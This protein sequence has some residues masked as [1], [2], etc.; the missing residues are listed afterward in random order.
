MKHFYLAM[1][2]LLLAACQQEVL[3]HDSS[4]VSQFT[5]MGVDGWQVSR[6][7]QPRIAGRASDPN[8][9]V[10]READFSGMRFDTS[11]QIDDPRYRQAATQPSRA[12][13]TAPAGPQPMLV[14]FGAPIV[15][16]GN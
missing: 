3:V 11:F 12:S 15:T 1:G 6:N 2:L 8:V 16:P 13:A 5:Q 9:R 4:I 7:D 10:V 14:P